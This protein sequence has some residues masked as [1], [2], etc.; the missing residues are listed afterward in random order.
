MK[1]NGLVVK[2]D[3][4]WLPSPAVQTHVL[5]YPRRLS[6]YQVWRKLCAEAVCEGHF[7]FKHAYDKDEGQTWVSVVGMPSEGWAM[8]PL[9]DPAIRV[10]TTPKAIADRYLP[11]RHP[12][13]G[14]VT[15]RWEGEVELCALRQGLLQY[16]E[17]GQGGDSG[18]GALWSRVVQAMPVYAA[19]PLYAED[20]SLRALFQPYHGA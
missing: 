18:V 8:L 13:F 1:I 16:A 19:A 12:A 10:V 15:Y 2:G 6:A 17:R 20:V 9:P 11:K 14:L 7:D 5:R 4:L 3:T